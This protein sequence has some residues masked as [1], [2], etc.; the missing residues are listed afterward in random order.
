M[1][2]YLIAFAILFISFFL[3]INQL[4][5]Q[6]F[7]E[8]AD[9]LIML[10]EK[11]NEPKE[12]V[13]LLNDIS[14][15]YRR[16]NADTV[17]YYGKKAFDLANQIKYIKGAAIARKNQGIS[18]HKK[19]API[20]TTKHY[21][22][23]A[24]KLAQECNDFYT[25]AACHNNIALLHRQKQELYTSIQHYLEGIE[26]LDQNFK[27]DQR[28][29][30]L[31]LANISEGYRLMD[32]YDNALFYI[33]KTFAM[34][35]K[36]NYRTIISMYSNDYGK[37]LTKLKKYE[38]AK[39]VFER[40]IR[41][42]EELNDFMSKVWILNHYADL[43]ITLG[44]YSHAKELV[45]QSLNLATEKNAL[46]AILYSKLCLAR[47]AFDRKDYKESIHQCNKIIA[48]GDLEHR[49]SYIQEAR[50]LLSLNLEKT[51]DIKG[52]LNNIRTYNLTRDTI[53]KNEKIALT[54][55]L[56]TRYR[57]Q[58]KEQEIIFL[59]KEKKLNEKYI[60]G[61]IVFCFISVFS[62][63]FI[64]YLLFKTRSKEK[65]IKEKNIELQKYI[66]YNLELENFAYIASHDLKTPIRTIISF[67]Q[68]LKAKAT[69]KLN[70]NQK[71]YLDFIIKGTKEMS[72]LI[73]DLLKY[74][75]VNRGQINPQKIEVREFID[76]ILKS[77]KSYLDEKSSKIKMDIQTP[78]IYGD[79]I[80]L[81]QVFQNLILNGVKFHKPYE[82]P[83]ILI[84]SKTEKNQILF[85]IKDN[86]IGIEQ[87]Y[88]DK[89][90][91][92][93]KKLNSKDDYQGSGIGLSIC[94]KVIEL[95]NG[96]IWVNSAPGKGTSFFFSLPYSKN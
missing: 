61:L 8:T 2:K 29:K 13:D 83:E 4:S 72:N 93:F 73:N 64:F 59:E 27:K 87:D 63:G 94:K 65:I 96:K 38:E 80:K 35:E 81:G 18:F 1:S 6:T 41:M 23:E 58:E 78:F 84:R 15:A 70:D 76:N 24:A 46:D 48:E 88:F 22:M 11:I 26:I 66:E 9:S 31:M 92:I 49:G 54:V 77:N 10:L 12:K 74:S 86:G 34:A 42:N 5:A 20:D 40:G 62:A 28:L 55:E 57:S 91:L 68:I 44:N 53:L 25:Q 71:D 36:N 39:L 37:I 17:F 85:E 67:S 43:E 32:E 75:K 51:G 7:Q 33:K 69:D 14:Y 16:L 82:K 47:I 89:I 95:H 60:N 50:K 90:F 79:K 45:L 52:A 19:S 56:N 30:A 3:K 21:Y